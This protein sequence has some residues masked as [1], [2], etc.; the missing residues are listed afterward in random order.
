MWARDR[1]ARRQRREPEL[2]PERAHLVHRHDVRVILRERRAQDVAQLR[3]AEPLGGDVP[4]L[5][6]EIATQVV[7][8]HLTPGERVDRCPR[9]HVHACSGQREQRELEPEPAGLTVCD[10]GVDSGR[11]RLDLRAVGLAE[12]RVLRLGDAR[13]VHRAQEAVAVYRG[14]AEHLAQPARADPAGELHLPEPVLGVNVALGEEEV[15]P[16]RR[17]HVRH[18]GVVAEN[19]HL[20][21]E[22]GYRYGAADV[23]KRSSDRPEDD[24]GCD[25]EESEDPGSHP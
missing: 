10:V 14:L 6:G 11:V 15:V 8:H 21:V 24:T 4:Q 12:L 13:E 2:F 19:L 16:G 7:G 20:S 5:L 3:A 1:L 22:A 23:R 17:P 25:D 18:A 9:F